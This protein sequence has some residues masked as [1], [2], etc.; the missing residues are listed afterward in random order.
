MFESDFSQLP[1]QGFIPRPKAWPQ[2]FPQELVSP[3]KS[4][5]TRALGELAESKSTHKIAVLVELLKHEQDPDLYLQAKA[6]LLQLSDSAKTHS[7]WDPYGQF[8]I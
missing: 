3:E 1:V 2:N 6:L 5:R 4:L 8:R 7:R